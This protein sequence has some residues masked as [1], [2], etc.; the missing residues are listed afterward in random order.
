MASTFHCKVLFEI[1]MN[2]LLM[3][4]LTNCVND[5]KGLLSMAILFLEK[6]FVTENQIWAVV[7]VKH[8]E[9]FHVLKTP[10]RCVFRSIS[11]KYGKPYLRDQLDAN[12]NCQIQFNTTVQY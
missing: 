5:L 10:T 1:I 2:S 8:P 7:M 9:C 4:F 6:P 12:I 3:F 11:N